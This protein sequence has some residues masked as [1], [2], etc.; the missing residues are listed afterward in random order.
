M[1]HCVMDYVVSLLTVACGT[2]PVMLSCVCHR[3]SAAF[4]KILLSEVEVGSR[5][6]PQCFLMLVFIP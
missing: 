4:V 6:Q 3:Q 1:K 5:G 2:V